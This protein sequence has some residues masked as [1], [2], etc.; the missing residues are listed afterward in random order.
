MIFLSAAPWWPPARPS[1]ACT[2][3]PGPP[4]ILIFGFGVRVSQPNREIGRVPSSDAD[5]R[6]PP[7]K[8][9][10]ESHL[11]LVLCPNRSNQ[12][13]QQQPQGENYILFQFHADFLQLIIA[14]RFPFTDQ[15]SVFSKSG[16][17]CFGSEYRP[18][19]LV[20]DW[21][22]SLS[23]Q[24]TC[25][26]GACVSITSSIPNRAIACKHEIALQCISSIGQRRHNACRVLVGNMQKLYT[27][28][29]AVR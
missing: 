2:H 19:H 21:A 24:A 23:I 27:D 26:K 3:H 13:D 9:A 1:S 11:H 22:H 17:G 25:Q 4:L 28:V 20:N 5:G 16:A 14:Q 8:G 7:G 6:N 10:D 29:A 18:I 12:N 15:T